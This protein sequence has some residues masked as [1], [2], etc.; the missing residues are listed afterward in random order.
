MATGD[1]YDE[2]SGAHSQKVR[3]AS[4]GSGVK[5]VTLADDLTRELGTVR[6]SL[7]ADGTPLS[8][9]F[10]KAFQ[11]GKVYSVTAHRTAL[12]TDDEYAWLLRTPNSG[13]EIYIAFDTHQ[14]GNA[15]TTFRENP[16]ISSVGTLATTHAINRDDAQSI[17]S[18]VYF[19]ASW[20]SLGTLLYYTNLAAWTAQLYGRLGLGTN[21]NN[22]WKLKQNE[23]Y[24]WYSK[25]LEDGCEVGI[26]LL[27]I[28]V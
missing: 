12:N 7:N 15:F 10:D 5:S 24:I 13:T 1:A 9:L 17:E 11:A 14:T 3:I 27:I 2:G 26:E 6:S 22:I 21:L 16:T 28:E 18:L 23:D 20:S 19:N 4:D 25:G 8:L